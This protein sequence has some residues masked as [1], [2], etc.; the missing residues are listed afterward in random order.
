[1]Q[2][3]T[4][5]TSWK[6]STCS[7]LPQSCASAH[8]HIGHRCYSL[9]ISLSLSLTLSLS[10]SLSPVLLLHHQ[11][12]RD[13]SP[14]RHCLITADSRTRCLRSSPSCSGAQL[15]RLA[16]LAR[17]LPGTKPEPAGLRHTRRQRH[18]VVL[19]LSSSRSRL[20]LLLT[21]CLLCLCLCLY[22]VCRRRDRPPWRAAMLRSLALKACT[23]GT[24]CWSRSPHWTRSER[25]LSNG[26]SSGCASLPALVHWHNT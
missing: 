8:R 17:C 10:L 23:A 14:L 21:R 11:H 5:A 20:Q 18:C 13:P 1:V 19:S 4:C 24:S 2:P 15:Q 6:P 16:K 25:S 9:S 12:D 7:L 3:H 26:G 22:A